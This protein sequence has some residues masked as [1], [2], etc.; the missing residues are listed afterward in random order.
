MCIR[1][2]YEHGEQRISPTGAPRPDSEHSS[3][4][5]GVLSVMGSL[6]LESGEVEADKETEEAREN[7][8]RDHTN[9]GTADQAPQTPDNRGL[10][11][12]ERSKT[13]SVVGD[14]RLSQ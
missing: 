9:G 2:S 6:N 5:F 7:Q 3:A 4:S 1:D 12:G 8:G 11:R 14:G 13:S 10:P